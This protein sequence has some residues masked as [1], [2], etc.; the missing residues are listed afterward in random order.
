[1]LCSQQERHRELFFRNKR[2][3][4]SARKGSGQREVVL[5]LCKSFL[6]RAAAKSESPSF[7]L[8]GSLLQGRRTN[9]MGMVDLRGG[10][11]SCIE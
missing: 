5:S 1:M 9:V 10:E 6:P 4:Y 7:H 8:G 3:E 11:E 2:Q